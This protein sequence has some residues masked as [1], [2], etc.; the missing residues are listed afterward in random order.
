MFYG[1][2]HAL[3]E[4]INHIGQVMHFQTI[5]EFLENDAILQ[6]LRTIGMDHAQ[7]YG[8]E[9]PRLSGLPKPLY[10]LETGISFAINSSSRLWMR[11]DADQCK[12][13]CG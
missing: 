3:V 7:E 11:A 13:N 12:L 1:W 10:S 9:K 4:A 2:H 5:A 6:A 8:I